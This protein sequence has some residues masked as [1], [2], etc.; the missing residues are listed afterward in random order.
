MKNIPL[1]CAV[2][3]FLCSLLSSQAHAASAAD[4]TTSV[5]PK[6]R[7]GGDPF[8]DM[9]SAIYA[10]TLHDMYGKVEV[11]PTPKFGAGFF[12]TSTDDNAKPNYYAQ[13]WARDCGRGV[14]ELA[15]LGF[16]KEALLVSRYFLAHINLKDHWGREIHRPYIPHNASELDGNA[17]ILSAICNSWK[18]NGRDKKIGAEF[19]DG[20]APVIGWTGDLIDNSPHNGLLPSISELSGNPSAKYTVYSIF[21][22]YGMRVALALVREM[23][24]E[25]GKTELA[26]KIANMQTK[27]DAG[28]KT[29]ISDGKKS[30]APDGCWFN[31]I[32][33][34]MGTAYD[35]SDWDGTAW[36]I[37]HWTRQLPY[38]QDYDAG[39]DSIGGPF[40]D[41]HRASYALVKSW[42]VKSEFFRKYGFVSNSGST[43][44][45]DRHD[46]T[47][48][49]YGQGFF[50]QAALMSDDVNTYSKCLEGIARLGYDGNVVDQ[51]SYERNPFLMAECFNYENYEKGMDHT[52]GTHRNGRRELME[53]PGDEG[54]LVQEAEIIKAFALVVGVSC[55]NNKLIIKPRLPWL[56][57]E[58][59]C[60][61]YPV[62]D[63]RGT[64]R[65][66]NFK[67]KHDRW[68]R[69]CTLRISAGDGQFESIDVRFGPFP[70]IT[71]NPTK[72]EIDE[73]ENC[74]WVWQRG[75]KPDAS[76]IVLGLPY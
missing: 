36:P 49:G 53:N 2:Y 70:R 58:V 60:I 48:G 29:L 62:I 31:G 65:R 32:D 14:M 61:D 46:E 8:A 59:E 1:L 74:S 35:I 42:M 40:A 18:V 24:Q 68:L 69:E 28:L 3:C 44:M 7:F 19:C 6:V 67:F 64:V 33:S 55:E 71:K 75:I 20:I 5:A 13:M 27:L 30:Y 51:M 73:S 50:T 57:N 45:G 76:E 11:E 16:S 54:N 39:T 15:R 43:G 21:G 66:I 23:A 10:E 41:I 72:L 25:S 17:W 52:F 47:M 12:H 34:R 9:A 37:W 38:I 56:W 26:D 63:N 4:H 22:N